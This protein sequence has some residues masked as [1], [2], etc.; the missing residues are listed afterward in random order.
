METV[1]FGELNIGEHFRTSP[2]GSLYMKCAI[3][4]S[5]SS[6][7]D[8]PNDVW[9]VNF[10]TGEVN[11]WDGGYLVIREPKKAKH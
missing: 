11:D 4:S 7:E 10:E 2:N 8:M 6:M 5:Y 3:R 1:E 9:A